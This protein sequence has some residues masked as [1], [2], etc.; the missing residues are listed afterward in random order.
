MLPNGRYDGA[1]RPGRAPDRVPA[2]VI[3]GKSHI[4]ACSRAFR[5]MT[6]TKEL[7][8]TAE[9]MTQLISLIQEYPEEPRRIMAAVEDGLTLGPARIIPMRD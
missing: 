5:V 4:G 2:V 7:L 3:H 9:A 6:N 8:L 1:A